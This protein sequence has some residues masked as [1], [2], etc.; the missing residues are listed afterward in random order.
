M[1]KIVLAMATIY[2]LG[3]A[4]GCL[5][6]QTNNL[7]VNWKA[8]KTLGKIGV[9][10]KFTDVSYN[11]NKLEAKNFNELLVGSK[12]L[13][14]TRK[15][16]TNNPDRDTTLVTFFF[17]K[18]SDNQVESTITDIKAFKRVKDEPRRGIV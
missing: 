11:P 17:N 9:D 4:G 8:Y 13:I 1:K 2:S 15:I 16:D 3:Q 14:A 18:L 6:T 5:L 12:V 7:N 10:G